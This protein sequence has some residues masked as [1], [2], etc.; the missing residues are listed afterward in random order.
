MISCDIYEIRRFVNSS[1]IAEKHGGRIA[2]K[3]VYGAGSEF[4]LYLPKK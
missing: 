3:S 1:K 2:V 4:T